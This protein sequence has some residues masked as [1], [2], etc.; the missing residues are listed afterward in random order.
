MVETPENITDSTLNT[1]KYDIEALVESAT[2]QADKILADIDRLNTEEIIDKYSAKPTIEPVYRKRALVPTKPTFI[3]EVGTGVLGMLEAV[4]K[5]I[6]T[7]EQLKNPIQDILVGVITGEKSE[8]IKLLN[9]VEAKVTKDIAWRNYRKQALAGFTPTAATP[10]A[11]RDQEVNATMLAK[12]QFYSTPAGQELLKRQAAAGKEL[13]DSER[14][15]VFNS[16]MLE[17][18]YNDTEVQQALGV[19][20]EEIEQFKSTHAAGSIA[21][22]V[23]KWYAASKVAGVATPFKNIPPEQLSY[24][25]KI[26]QSATGTGAFTG[27]LQALSPD[28]SP[29]EIAK[30]TA[31][32]VAFGAALPVA[33]TVAKKTLTDVQQ[34]LFKGVEAN[35][36]TTLAKARFAAKNEAAINSVKNIAKAFDQKVTGGAATKAQER[37]AQLR[38]ADEAKS[39]KLYKQI[40]KEIYKPYIGKDGKLKPKYLNPKTGRVKPQYL[41]ESGNFDFSKTA[42]KRGKTDRLTQQ[43]LQAFMLHKQSVLQNLADLNTNTYNV[44]LRRG[45]ADTANALLMSGAYQH[46]NVELYKQGL[47]NLDKAKYLNDPKKLKRLSAIMRGKA[48]PTKAEEAMLKPIKDAIRVNRTLYAKQAGKL[49]SQTDQS[50]YHRLLAEEIHDAVE[51]GKRF[52][53]SGRKLKSFVDSEVGR[54]ISSKI[55]SALENVSKTNKKNF[56]NSGARVPK[57]L[58]QRKL[59]DKEWETALEGNPIKVI[60]NMLLKQTPQ[61][62]NRDIAK[63]LR[64]TVTYM[65]KYGAP[66]SA[67]EKLWLN[68]V[69][70]KYDPKYGVMGELRKSWR[71]W[72]AT[73]DLS[74]AMKETLKD[75]KDPLTYVMDKVLTVNA[76]FGLGARPQYIAKNMT[77]PLQ[78]TMIGR[79]VKITLQGQADAAKLMGRSLLPNSLKKELGEE[80][81]LALKNAK[82][83]R[84]NNLA[85]GAGLDATVKGKVTT[86]A[87][88]ALFANV[89]LSDRA[90]VV[91]TFISNLR[92]GKQM[93][94]TGKELV[95]FARMETALEQHLYTWGT[96]SVM[97]SNPASKPLAMFTGWGFDTLDFTL[98]ARQNLAKQFPKYAKAIEGQHPLAETVKW[99]ALQYGAVAML[100]E[101]TGF[102]LSS[103]QPHN[104]VKATAV[105]T[106]LSWVDRLVSLTPLA[107]GRGTAPHIQNLVGNWDDFLSRFGL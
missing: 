66:M 102:N 92:W 48:V 62:A 107:S 28:R 18:M 14:Q 77:Q 35:T 46:K 99:A 84:G 50:Y 98:H 56:F 26:I 71:Q 40:E 1:T 8:S 27:T 97:G 85:L 96:R 69:A 70:N 41:D 103:A 87:R 32:G 68:Q 74:P 52:N 9:V 91:G 42:L 76:A 29:E 33:G 36:V 44:L 72:V 63:S 54:P 51:T 55:V 10:A 104:M 83:L 4:A 13:F 22:E 59:T 94:M 5:N 6:Y 45:D 43:Q 2:K 95:S 49:P 105:D 31:G 24:I 57:F 81:I 39:K 12:K 79:P 20:K 16:G 30:A 93:G 21:G 75:I 88:E 90:N 3:E 37:F 67:P 7:I 80:T 106:P 86:G 64:R 19:S 38:L 34:Y 78:G 60:N 47:N 17:R 73:T 11:R 82:I 53:Y 65:D 23:T 101:L 58:K 15:R 61:L 89:T 25:Q 100:S